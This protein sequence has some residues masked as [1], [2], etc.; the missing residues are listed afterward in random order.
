[1]NR[2]AYLFQALRDM[3]GYVENGGSGSV[4]FYQDDATRTWHVEVGKNSYWADSLDEAIE[5]AHFAN[6]ELIAP[7]AREL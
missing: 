7:Q 4:K 1:M 3:A 6:N 2:H 5:K